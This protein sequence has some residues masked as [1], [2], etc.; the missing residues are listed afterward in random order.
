[1]RIKVNIIVFPGVRRQE[2]RTSVY[3]EP[4][5]DLLAPS[6]WD[7]PE[8]SAHSSY[9]ASSWT[10]PQLYNTASVPGVIQSNWDTRGSVSQPDWRSLSYCLIL[11]LVHTTLHTCD[12]CVCVVTVSLYFFAFLNFFNVILFCMGHYFSWSRGSEPEFITYVLFASAT[13]HF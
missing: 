2:C 7:A 3:S 9:C 1:M 13:Y 5:M 8:A 6:C 4:Q 11:W 10:R 12:F